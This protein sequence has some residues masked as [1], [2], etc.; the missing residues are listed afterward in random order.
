MTKLT[1]QHIERLIKIEHQVQYH[2][3][4]PDNVL[5]FTIVERQSPILLSAPH[6]SRTYR[7]RAGEL[8]HEEDEY[9]A[10]MALLLGELCRVSVIATVWQTDDSDPNDTRE[11]EQARRSSPYKKAVRR[12]SERGVRWIIDLHGAG[13]HSSRM[14]P[15]QLVDLGTGRD[16]LS[17]SAEHL[18]VLIACI[19][20]H[21]GAGAADREDYPGWPARVAG[22]SITAF[23][24]GKLG[25]SA[26]QIE[27]KPEVRVARRRPEAVL[28]RKPPSQGG[29]P[30]AAPPAQLAAMMQA[31]A[32]FIE[33]L[34]IRL[35]S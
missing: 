12:L 7:N 3:S 23:A 35:S 9:T 2:E 18:Q 21:L 4:P 25:L 11:D 22:R 15:A 17:L 29:G 26:V 13:C 10:G 32:D 24:Q 31:L 27:M 34:K 33:Y 19:E 6:G 14:A 30:Y 8:W 16:G 28:Y 20:Q 1:A 5:P